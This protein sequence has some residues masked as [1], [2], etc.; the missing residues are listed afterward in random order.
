MRFQ[1]FGK[2]AVC[3]LMAMPLLACSS[4]EKQS[5]MMVD[6]GAVL[7]SGDLT[8][9]KAMEA[10]APLMKKDVAVM[11]VIEDAAVGREVAVD[12]HLRHIRVGSVVHLYFTQSDKASVRWEV[13]E[14]LKEYF[15]VS[16]SGGTLSAGQ[17]DNLKSRRGITLHKGEEVNLYVSA[18]RLETLEM[19][20][21]TRA[22]L[23]NVSQQEPVD[24][25]LSGASKAVGQTVMSSGAV[26][27]QCS[28]ASETAFKEVYSGDRVGF[29]CSG[30]GNL[31]VD[32]LTG[33]FYSL[34]C[35]GASKLTLTRFNRTEALDV[36]A[37]GAGKVNVNGNA[38]EARFTVS[39]ASNVYYA[40]RTDRVTVTCSGSSS[41]RL[42]GEAKEASLN[43]SGVS[44]I[45]ASGMK[46]DK[47]SRNETKMAKIT[48]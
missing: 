4:S 19:S 12:G 34:N 32:M 18:P 28:G 37:S 16:Y 14:R 15:S 22:Q 36:R 13:P 5:E 48:L 26:T 30:A 6:D 44:K 27:I 10:L 24:V 39:G 42:D 1:L 20:G 8:Y 40:G 43:A 9:E 46:I 41:A 23:G 29:N 35:S 31:A 2:S 47:V 11:T 25:R 21:A 3:L 38:G 17:N 7:I 45:S 33:K